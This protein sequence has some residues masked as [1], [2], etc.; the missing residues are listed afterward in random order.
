MLE[1]HHWEESTY[2]PHTACQKHR[3]HTKGIHQ[4]RTDK[5]EENCMH[6]QHKKGF[7]FVCVFIFYTWKKL[8]VAMDS[9]AQPTNSSAKECK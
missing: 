9:Y 2:S 4:S 8:P 6:P 7:F 3:A 5:L 1:S